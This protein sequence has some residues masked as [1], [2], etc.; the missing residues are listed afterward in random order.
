MS[1]FEGNVVNKKTF[2]EGCVFCNVGFLK[3]S[4]FGWF[5]DIESVGGLCNWDFNDKTTHLVCSKDELDSHP[6]IKQAIAAGSCWVVSEEFLEQSLAKGKRMDE[7]HFSLGPVPGKLVAADPAAGFRFDDIAAATQVPESGV[8]P[9]PSSPKPKLSVTGY[10]AATAAFDEEDYKITAAIVLQVTEIDANHN[11][12][13]SIELHEG[14]SAKGQP[15]SRVFTHYGRVADLA[16]NPMAGQKEVRYTASPK[17]SKLFFDW[18][19]Y[20]KTGPSKGYRRVELSHSNIGSDLMRKLSQPQDSS[21]PSSSSSSS[22]TSSFGLSSS[23]SSGQSNLPL[24]VQ[25]LVE[26]VFS[27]AAASLSK[28]ISAKITQ[29]GI[30]TPLGVL[31]LAQVE[32]GQALLDE[33]FAILSTVADGEMTAAQK[34]RLSSLSGQFY[35]VV[36]HPIGRSKADVQGSLILD[37]TAWE[38]KQETVQLMRDMVRAIAEACG[39]ETE[40]DNKYKALKNTVTYLA[41]STL[42]CQDVTRYVLDSQLQQFDSSIQVLNVFALQ[43]QPEFALFDDASRDIHPQHVLFHGSR[44]ANYVGIL[45][46]GCLLPRAVTARGVK[47]TDA[48]MLGAGIYYGDRSSTAAQ[49]CHPAAN[50]SRFLLLSRVALG[51]SADFDHFDTTLSAPPDG[52]QSTHGV[53]NSPA[54]PSAFKDDEWV[55]YNATQ[56]R[57]EYLVEFLSVPQKPAAADTR[58]SDLKQPVPFRPS[59]GSYSSIS[60]FVPAYAYASLPPSQPD[61]FSGRSSADPSIS[62]PTRSGYVDLSPTS[63]AEPFEPLSSPQNSLSGYVDTNPPSGYPQLST[64]IPSIPS[65][66]SN[67][68]PVSTPAFSSFSSSYSSTSPYASSGSPYSSTPSA[69]PSTSTDA[70]GWPDEFAQQKSVEDECRRSNHYDGPSL[71]LDVFSPS[72]QHL[73]EPQPLPVAWHLPLLISSF[74]QSNLVRSFADFQ[75]NWNSFSAN[76]FAGADWSNMFAAGGSVLACATGAG[77]SQRGHD[78]DLFFYGLSPADAD[79]KLDQL[80]EVI[81]GNLAKLPNNVCP[82]PIARTKNAITILGCPPA[83]HVQ[84][85]LRLYSCPTEVLVGFDIDSCCF[86]FDGTRTYCLPRAARALKYHINVVDVT[87][88]SLSYEH[89]LWKYAKRGFRIACPGLD[90]ARVDSGLYDVSRKTSGLAKLL[91]LEWRYGST[92]PAAAA[93]TNLFSI[94]PDDQEALGFGEGD[95]D[96]GLL[97]PYGAAFPQ[98]RILRLLQQRNRANFFIRKALNRGQT[99]FGNLVVVGLQA[100]KTGSALSTTGPTVVSS[101]LSNATPS[102]LTNFAGPIVWRTDNPGGQGGLATGS[103]NPLPAD[104]WETDAYANHGGQTGVIPHL[105]AGKL[106]LVAPKAAKVKPTKTPRFAP[107]PIRAMFAAK[108]KKSKAAKFI[109]PSHIAQPMAPIPSKVEAKIGVAKKR[110]GFAFG[111]TAPNQHSGFAQPDFQGFGFGDHKAGGFAPPTPTPPPMPSF[112]GASFFGAA[113]P[114]Q[115]SASP[116]P[117]TPTGRM[118]LLISMLSKAS[119][120]TDHQRL[121]LK[122][123]LIAGDP[124][125]W[126][127]LE[128]F[129]IDGDF[130]ELADTLI[131]LINQH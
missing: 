104:G 40:L 45:S 7:R 85:I 91:L 114:P 94:T 95:Y 125:L 70:L 93:S 36:P 33:M 15:V 90:R 73:F 107:Q 115:A 27:E 35:T 64:S 48:G 43:R 11:K 130:Q 120:I 25:R 83:P 98:N 12:Y 38:I 86:G 78:I 39:E 79:R 29:R 3:R 103:F 46:R 75:T 54:T 129:E 92:A 87:R 96:S 81:K 56:Q 76:L 61:S 131:R 124:N 20:E 84:I 88:R 30:E 77:P 57:Q 108:P 53:R 80:Y 42:E 51:K 16:S 13:Y 24:P 49:Y 52:F 122:K 4:S 5:N 19:L 62:L 41:P 47:R 23:L 10:G 18:L 17:E 127:A 21:P 74:A 106:A 1:A 44:A 66:S 101:S 31:T 109:R 117:S 28:T 14:K 32:K 82:D 128:V 68:T 113:A 99:P 55:I 111:A 69:Y 59:P 50:S 34:T 100:V 22:S 97:I 8:C 6:T 119:L 26:C 89:R 37:L 63:S 102:D 65:T 110:G 116:S 118:L 121:A 67:S 105:P 123:H 72:N 112:G 71:L 58:L 9:K 2:F 126:V 60:S